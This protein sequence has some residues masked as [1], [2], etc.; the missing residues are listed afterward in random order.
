MPLRRLTW[1]KYQ[2][3]NYCKRV[4]LGLAMLVRVIIIAWRTSIIDEH[5]FLTADPVGF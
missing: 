1:Q 2:H 3:D 5:K 4:H